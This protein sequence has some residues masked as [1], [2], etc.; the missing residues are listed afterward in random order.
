FSQY[1]RSGDR[2]SVDRSAWRCVSGSR[3]SPPR[4]AVS[5]PAAG[6]TADLPKPEALISPAAIQSAAG[7]SA[8]KFLLANDLRR[9]TPCLLP[10]EAGD[11]PGGFVPVGVAGHLSRI[12]NGDRADQLLNLRNELRRNAKPPQTHSH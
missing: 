1:L 9:Q 11:I 12:V 10:H 5:H 3:H 7:R 4:R 6:A 2:A 8:P